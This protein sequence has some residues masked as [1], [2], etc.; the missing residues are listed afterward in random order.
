MTER[1]HYENAYLAEWNARI[2]ERIKQDGKNAL[3]LDKSAFYPTGGGQPHDSGEISGN[4][5]IEVYKRDDGAII[6]FVEFF[7]VRG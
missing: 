2:V 7:S 3:I 5:V 4:P 6:H 1:L